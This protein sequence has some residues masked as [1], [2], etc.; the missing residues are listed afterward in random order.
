MPAPPW[1]SVQ[2]S[3]AGAVLCPKPRTRGA[4]A[5]RGQMTSQGNSQRFCRSGRGSP[6]QAAV[7][8]SILVGG[9]GFSR[10]LAYSFLSCLLIRVGL[11][12]VQVSQPGLSL[13]TRDDITNHTHAMPR[14]HAHPSCTLSAALWARRGFLTWRASAAPAVGTRKATQGDPGRCLMVRVLSS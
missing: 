13:D 6:P 12:A 3:N 4:F 14:W 11:K 8:S 5:S 7:N 2:S 10:S 9:C 1:P